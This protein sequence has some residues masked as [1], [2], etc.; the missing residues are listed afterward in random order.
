ME[1]NIHITAIQRQCIVDH[2]PQIKLY[3]KNQIIGLEKN[4]A[5]EIRQYNQ[6]KSLLRDVTIHYPHIIS[7]LLNPTESNTCEDK[8]CQE[9]MAEQNHDKNQTRGTGTRT[10]IL[11]AKGTEPGDE[12]NTMPGN[13]T[14]IRRTIE[15]IGSM[16]NTIQSFNPTTLRVATDQMIL[17]LKNINDKLN[18]IQELIPGTL[19]PGPGP[20]YCRT[21]HQYTDQNIQGQGQDQDQDNNNCNYREIHGLVAILDDNTRAINNYIAGSTGPGIQGQGFTDIKAYMLPRLKDAMMFMKLFRK[22]NP[23]IHDIHTT[24]TID[25]I[26]NGWLELGPVSVSGEDVMSTSV[27]AMIKQLNLYKQ[28]DRNNG[29][30]GLMEIFDEFVR[31]GKKNCMDEK[32]L[33]YYEHD[34]I[35]YCDFID[36]Y[37]KTMG[38]VNTNDRNK[39]IEKLNTYMAETY[40]QL[41]VYYFK[42]FKDEND[43]NAIKQDLLKDIS[44]YGDMFRDMVYRATIDHYIELITGLNSKHH[45]VGTIDQVLANAN[46]HWHQNTLPEITFKFIVD[47]KKLTGCKNMWGNEIDNEQDAITFIHQYNELMNGIDPVILRNLGLPGTI[48]LIPGNYRKKYPGMQYGKIFPGIDPWHKNAIQVLDDL[49]DRCMELNNRSGSG[50]GSGPGPGPGLIA[51]LFSMINH[52]SDRKYSRRTGSSWNDRDRSGQNIP[53]HLIELCDLSIKQY[54]TGY[55]DMY[56]LTKILILIATEQIPKKKHTLDDY[57]DNY[58]DKQT[59]DQYLLTI[60]KMYPDMTQALDIKNIEHYH[61]MVKYLMAFLKNLSCSLMD[62]DP[63]TVIDIKNISSI[64]SRIRAGLLLLDYFKPTIQYYKTQD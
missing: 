43:Y 2:R 60:T 19:E 26:Y 47:L 34:E 11:I 59:I 41:L 35:K 64:N 20:G 23:S 18:Q 38:R 51:K 3:I 48:R 42:T 57:L 39:I 52:P 8:L 36:F 54:R 5:T 31:I 12:N 22:N 46:I 27:M 14:K 45:T 61:V 16:F 32:I 21:M 7:F 17:G 24:T 50:P 29:E 63:G 9:I 53:D 13:E 37:N 56:G 28:Y 55:N 6:I 49:V 44:G 15:I 30:A 62:Q 40:R 10:N 58:L 1:P 33:A 25:Q 4:Y